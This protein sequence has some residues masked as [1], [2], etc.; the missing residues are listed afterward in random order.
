MQP[1][2]CSTVEDDFGRTQ[3]EL[4]GALPICSSLTMSEFACG[5]LRALHQIH[6]ATGKITG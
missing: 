3:M 2:T 1:S 4:S 6:A 5:H